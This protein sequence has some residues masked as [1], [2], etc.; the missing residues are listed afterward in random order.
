VFRLSNGYGTG[1]N[2]MERNV[3]SAWKRSGVIEL[4]AIWLRIR[5]SLHWQP[6]DLPASQAKGVATFD[7]SDPANPTKLVNSS[8]EIRFTRRGFTAR[9]FIMRNR[10]GH[11]R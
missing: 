1:A 10:T 4:G 7:I 11:S 3:T 8:P 5:S 2:L 6:V 9:V